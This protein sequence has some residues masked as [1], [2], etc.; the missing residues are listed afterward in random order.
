[1]EDKEQQFVWMTQMNKNVDSMSVKSKKKILYAYVIY[2]KNCLLFF[3]NKLIKKKRGKHWY[4]K[5]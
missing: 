5:L 4:Q 1:M 3:Y 2:K